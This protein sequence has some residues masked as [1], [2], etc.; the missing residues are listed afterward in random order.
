M[1]ELLIADY[2]KAVHLYRYLLYL[3]TVTELRDSIS[4][5]NFPQRGSQQKEDKERRVTVAPSNSDGGP[6]GGGGGGPGG[7][8]GA[9]GTGGDGGAGG[10]T[11]ASGTSLNSQSTVVV[12]PPHRPPLQ[13]LWSETPCCVL[14]KKPME[15]ILMR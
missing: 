2:I 7:G 9:S 1:A 3:Q 14:T 15:K 11:S 13:R 8:G 10:G 5:L 6:V 12:M 4:R